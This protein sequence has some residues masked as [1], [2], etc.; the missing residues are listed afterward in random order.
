MVR[1]CERCTVRVFMEP[2]AYMRRQIYEYVV[3]SGRGHCGIS[4]AT[5]WLSPV[6]GSFAHP[7]YMQP[8]ILLIRLT[9]GDNPVADTISGFLIFFGM[10]IIKQ[11]CV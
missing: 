10:M 2:A 9:L 1:H 6:R 8:D 4:S 7:K 3:I 11:T 5:L